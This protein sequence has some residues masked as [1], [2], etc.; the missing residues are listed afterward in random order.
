MRSI[1]TELKALL[2]AAFPSFTAAYV[3]VH[4]G[5]WL[6]AREGDSVSTT[7]IAPPPPPPEPAKGKKDK[8]GKDRR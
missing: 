7:E 8:K 5:L 4:G 2:Q 1:R 3:A 6:V